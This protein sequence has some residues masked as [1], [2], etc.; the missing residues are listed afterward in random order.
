MWM[1]P[2]NAPLLAVL[3]AAAWHVSA[4][5]QTLDLKGPSHIELPLNPAAH[6][7]FADF[8]KSRDH[9]REAAEA[10]QQLEK[11]LNGLDEGQKNQLPKELFDK[12]GKPRPI[13]D[14]NLK[15]EDLQRILD[16]LKN[17]PDAP[18]QGS[19][20]SKSLP[21][22]DEL[23]KYA[24]GLPNGARL[25]PLNEFPRLP[26]KQ[27]LPPI[28][29]GPRPNL[30]TQPIPPLP[31]EPERTT[32]EKSEEI[33]KDFSNLWDKFKNS[34]L[35]SSPT[36]RDLGRRLCQP[37]GSGRGAEADGFVEKLGR[38]GNSSWFK[39]IFGRLP[40]RASSNESHAPSSSAPGTWGFDA[41][42]RGSWTAVLWIVIAIVAGA[43]LWK[44]LTDRRAAQSA[45]GLSGWRLGPWPVDPAQV[46]T[47]EELIRAFEYLSLL[48]FGWA[49]RS[50]NHRAI[51]KRF[52]DQM[53][54]A[55]QHLATLYEKARYAP[56]ADPLP[57]DEVRDAR[58]DLC[59]LA[60]VAT[61]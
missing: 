20:A 27:D 36:L 16:Q 61:A 31:P 54:E 14:L 38:I 7:Q 1:R 2:R 22:W 37:L 29:S 11:L 50:W 32:E 12:D 21:K 10:L 59:L 41:P 33:K 3:V 19:D 56:P 58:R 6:G 53:A 48:R 43:A 49:A 9:S 40:A 34:S 60:G 17:L 30:P 44:L 42:G 8:L 45:T 25:R 13:G 28:V 23:K 46:T 35:G 15:K 39:N 47:R 26:A 4:F 51:A 55:A 52:G 18:V 5:A 57:D 24:D